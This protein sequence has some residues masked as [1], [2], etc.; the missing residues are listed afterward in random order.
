MFCACLRCVDV[1]MY[2]FIAFLALFGLLVGCVLGLCV[3][4][5]CVVLCVVCVVL[6]SFCYCEFCALYVYV[7]IHVSV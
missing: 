4:F 1:Y 6:I 3:F 7:Y 2:C 5:V